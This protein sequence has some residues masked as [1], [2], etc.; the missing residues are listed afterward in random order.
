MITTLADLLCYAKQM[1]ASDL[2]LS[3]GEKPRL[4]IDGDIMPIQTAVL[5]H[6][7]IMRLLSEIINKKQLDELTQQKELDFSFEIVGLC[8]FRANA[9][10]QSRGISAVFRLIIDQIPHIDDLDPSNTFKKLCQLNQGLILIT[11]ATGSGKSTTLAAMIDY[12]NQHRPIHILTI[13]DPIEFIHTSKIALINQREIKKDTHDFEQALTSAMREDPD[14]ILIGELRDL[15]SIRLALRAAETGHLVLATLHTN[16]APK[17]IDRIIDVFDAHEKNLI[18]SMI[19]ESLQAVISQT[20]IPKIN[21]GRVAAFE[22]MMATP[23]IR[24]LIR[25]NKVAQMRSAIQTG[26]SDGMMSFDGSLRQLLNQGLIDRQ[27]AL[28]FANE[29]ERL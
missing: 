5:S 24:N 25:E 15:S 27:T 8:R 12:M 20:L 6:D 26:M 16:N 10:Y 28:S 23:A 3:A 21:G 13:E 4:R 1:H 2:H 19:S 7:D 9:F 18:R 14:V 11:G 17:A 29:P 22:I